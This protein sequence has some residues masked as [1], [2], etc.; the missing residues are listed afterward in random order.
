MHFGTL[1]QAASPFAAYQPPLRTGIQAEGE[2]HEE[3]PGSRPRSESK[4]PSG[5]DVS[6]LYTTQT[7]PNTQITPCSKTPQKLKTFPRSTPATSPLERQRSLTGGLGGGGQ[8]SGGPERRR[9]HST[10]R[11]RSPLGGTPPKSTRG[12]STPSPS[13]AGSPS[14]GYAET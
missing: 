4:S 5:R 11:P 1:I 13:I 14:N 2:R 12:V 6:A 10:Q 7:P 3:L 9:S 8:A